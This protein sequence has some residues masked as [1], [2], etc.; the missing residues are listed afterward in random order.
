MAVFGTGEPGSCPGHFFM[1][2][3]GRHKHLKKKKSAPRFSIIYHI[4]VWGIG[5]LAPLL[6]E[7][8]PCTEAVQGRGGGGIH[9]VG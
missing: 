6:A 1:T 5:K 8:V 3:G 2:R 9:L 4:T 7:K